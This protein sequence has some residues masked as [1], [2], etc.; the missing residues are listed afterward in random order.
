[1]DRDFISIPGIW[2]EVSRAAI[3]NAESAA[4]QKN[5]KDLWRH[6]AK[7]DSVRDAFGMLRVRFCETH[8][9]TNSLEFAISTPLR[10]RDYPS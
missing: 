4:L 5:E 2:P 6:P 7:S 9:P 8:T 3:A 10:P 1:V